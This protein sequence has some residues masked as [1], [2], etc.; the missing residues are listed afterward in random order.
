MN[1]R[2]HVSSTSR[3]ANVG[4]WGAYSHKEPV[5]PAQAETHLTARR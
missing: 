3:A 2:P 1:E 5:S 4:N